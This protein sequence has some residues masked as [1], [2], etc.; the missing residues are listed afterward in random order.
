[1]QLCELVHEVVTM[2]EV[3]D[4]FVDTWAPT[5]S[6][7]HTAGGGHGETELAVFL[8]AI[9][10][11]SGEKTTVRGT[12]LMFSQHAHIQALFIFM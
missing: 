12:T 5:T 10:E 3:V 4:F 11:M 1:M 7:L 6:Q 8:K 2:E 9:L